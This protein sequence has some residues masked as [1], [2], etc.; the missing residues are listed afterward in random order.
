MGLKDKLTASGSPLSNL[1][2]AQG[3][4]NPGATK[5]SKLHANGSQPSYSLDGSNYSTVNKAYQEY[6]DGVPNNLPRPSQL[7]VNGINPKGAL[8]D[9]KTMSINDS[10][11]KGTYLNNLPK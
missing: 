9:P 2:G 11:K 8:S 10:F 5:T 6:D 1:N 4:T 7:D 3:K